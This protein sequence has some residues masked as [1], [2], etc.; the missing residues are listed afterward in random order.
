MI[1]GE[2]AIYSTD[3]EKTGLNNNVLVCGA[4]GCG[5]TMSIS[6]P[7]LL[8]TYNTSLI[9]TVTKRKLVYKYKPVF[10][11]RGYVVENLN[12]VHPQE[13]TVSF[14]PLQYVCSYQDITFL[15]ESIVKSDPRKERSNADPY[16]DDTAVS[17]L[18][19]EI[20]YVLMTVD[21][22]SFTDVLAFHDKLEIREPAQRNDPI[23]TSHDVLFRRLAMVAPHCFAVSCWKSFSGL[24]SR[25]AHCVFSALNTTLDNIFN[26]EL[27][28]MMA[29]EN[30]VNFERMATEKTVLFVTS[31]AVNPALQYFVNTFYAQAFKSLFEYAEDLPDGKLPIPV[32][33]LCDDFATG[34]RILNFPEYISIFREKQIS[35][36]LLLQSESQLE[37]M[38]GKGN[39]TT[40]INNCDTYLY[41][42]GMDLQTG[43]S[44][45]ERL[46]IPL[47]EVLYMPLGREYVFRRGQKPLQTTRYNIC[48]NKLYQRITKQYM[49]RIRGASEQKGGDDYDDNERAS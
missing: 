7:R 40:I 28:Q 29:I 3:C 18:S 41:M 4:S 21:N 49:N 19:A 1:L 11:Q 14:D 32:H 25:T 36:T 12:F 35:V 24:P 9:A 20:A 2:N 15:A 13:S 8:E 48:Q 5:K 17:L 38:Y 43:R 26:P 44:V 42:G 37:S 46:N 16:W 22:P 23:S 6:E 27:R 33:V 39:A 34:G 47:E 31:S 45:S 30:K 10:E